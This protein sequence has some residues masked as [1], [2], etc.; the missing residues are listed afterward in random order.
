MSHCYSSINIKTAKGIHNKGSMDTVIENY[1]M[2]SKDC[3]YSA[4]MAEVILNR[5]AKNQKQRTLENNFNNTKSSVIDIIEPS[6]IKVEEK[7]TLTKE[8]VVEVGTNLSVIESYMKQL[9]DKKETLLDYEKNITN[10]ICRD[11][12]L[13]DKLKL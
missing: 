2:P 6:N 12:E 1:G 7:E 4:E 8:D 3:K 5:I 11:N 9:I 10:I 13:I